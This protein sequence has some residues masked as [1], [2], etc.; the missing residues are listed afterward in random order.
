MDYKVIG[1][2]MKDGK[3]ESVVVESKMQYNVPYGWLEFCSNSDMFGR[4]YIGYWARGFKVELP[5]SDQEGPESPEVSA[6]ITPE[7]YDF[8]AAVLAMSDIPWILV[9]DETESL[10]KE[11]LDEIGDKA[12]QAFLNKE[13]LPDNCY[14]MTR[15]LAIKAFVMRAQRQGPDWFEDADGS[16]YDCAIQA[17]I[18]GEV[19]YG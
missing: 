1:E 2:E 6:V 13:K 18:F 19:K 7:E 4:D 3:L 16:D 11:Q 15:E 9:E 12:I 17:A 5:D 10:S 14:A 8:H